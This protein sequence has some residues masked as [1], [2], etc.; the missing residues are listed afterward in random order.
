M[1]IKELLDKLRQSIGKNMGGHYCGYCG[2][3]R[4]HPHAADCIVIL[5]DKLEDELIA[6]ESK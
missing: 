2:V 3:P 4:P 6:K 1:A 5:F